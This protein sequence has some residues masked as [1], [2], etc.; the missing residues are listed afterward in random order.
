MSDAKVVDKA[1][2]QRVKKQQKSKTVFKP[3][4]DNPLTISWCRSTCFASPFYSQRVNRPEIPQSL[5]NTFLGSAIDLLG[6]LKD[7]HH[8]RGLHRKRSRQARRRELLR[9]QGSTDEGVS[10]KRKRDDE[11]EPERDAKRQK[12]EVDPGH[13]E[14][15]LNPPLLLEHVYFGLSEVSKVLERY[16]ARLRGSVANSEV[17]GEN[18]TPRAIL[19]CR[20]DVNPPQLFSHIPYLVASCNTLI[21]LYHAR[22]KDAKRIP[23]LKLVNLSKGAESALSESIGLRRV[24]IVLLIVSPPVSRRHQFTLRSRVKLVL[25]TGYLIH[26]Q[27]FPVSLRHG[28]CQTTIDN[29]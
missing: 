11:T 28:F 13:L 10:K 7:Y 22:V 27:G 8:Q 1:V 2:S 21:T 26:Y 29:T 15:P 24:S 17:L 5:Q 16:I 9:V 3:V 6:C 14:E 20:W 23:E 4:L 18:A 25:E 19:A 12:M